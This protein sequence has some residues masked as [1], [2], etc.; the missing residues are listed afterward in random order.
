[1]TP[2]RSILHQRMM[3]TNGTFWV[4]MA[5][6]DL[7]ANIIELSYEDPDYSM[8]II[9]PQNDLSDLE[10]RLR[11]SGPDDLPLTSVLRKMMLR[12]VDLT[13]PQFEVENSKDFVEVF[14]E[15]GVED[16]FSEDSADLSD[17]SEDEDLHVDAIIHKAKVTIDETGSEAAAATSVVIGTRSSSSDEKPIPFEVNKP[18]I[19][20]ILDRARNLPLFFGRIVNPG[21]DSLRNQE[22][23]FQ[24]LKLKSS[25][26]INCEGYQDPED[27]ESIVFPCKGFDTKVLHQHQ[28]DQESLRVSRKI[29]F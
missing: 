21:R 28:E 10:D 11:S 22:E 29:T 3:K 26:G 14:R 24:K 20:A 16:V 13:L 7:N 15:L 5:D 6:E 19:F 23:R 17:I 12:N 8:L 9:V 25:A 4:A 2:T 18:F 1:M 27:P